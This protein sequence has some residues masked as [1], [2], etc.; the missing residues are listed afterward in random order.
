MNRNKVIF[1]IVVCVVAAG[2]AAAQTTRRRAT[3]RPAAAKPTPAPSATPIANSTVAQT[4]TTTSDDTIAMVNETA[5]SRQDIEADVSAI[6]NRDPD[7]YLRSYYQDPA[8]EIRESRERALDARINSMLLTA[9]AK[10]HGKSVDEIVESEIKSKVPPPTEAEIKAAYDANRAQIGNADLESVRAELINFIRNERGQELY[11]ALIRRL[12]MT[13]ALTRNADVNAP[14][15]APGTVL[16]SVNGEPI[17]IETIDERTRAYVN[18]LEQRIYNVRKQ[19][20]DRRINDLLVIAEANKRKV[21]S[22]EVIHTEITDKLTQPSDAQISKFYDENKAAIKTDLAGARQVITN[23]LQQQQQE[24]L[25]T[26]LAERLRASS[27]I[28]ILLKE[29]QTAPLNVGIAAGATRGDVNAA[30]T[31]VE[32]TDFQCSACGAMYP[33]VEDVLKAYGTRV[34]FVI[35]NFPLTTVHPNA[36]HAAEAAEAAKVQG[37]FWEY[38]DLMFK[39]QGS[40]DLDSLKKYATQVGL[41]RKRFDAD[42]E[43]GKYD[44]VI[45][46][47]IE[48][49]EV[50]G[51]E[52]TPSFFINGVVLT[53]YSVDGLRAAIDR[54]FARAGKGTR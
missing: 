48:D 53:E 38:I 8:K 41:E 36:F 7:V 6:I 14:K 24:K 26:A 25:E 32:F 50:L 16:V 46:R 17:R 11:T 35:R 44:P 42:L 29:P 15:L 9:E 2:I 13:N 45:N 37:K 22:E 47:D 34:R 4:S 19:V 28:Q 3:Q 5:I 21:G 27:K 40:L 52:A 31:V 1:T 23:Y 30:V 43:S 12:K 20:L 10:K 54:A 39:N 33:I 51:V 49:G 18:K